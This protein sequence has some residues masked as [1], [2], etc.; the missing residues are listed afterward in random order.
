MGGGRVKLRGG[1]EENEG[2][3]VRIKRE[4]AGTAAV[5]VVEGA[6]VTVEGASVA[7]MRRRGPMVDAGGRGANP[8]RF[9]RQRWRITSR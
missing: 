6:S 7:V 2:G 1:G 9:R 8:S 5:T 3:A 4:G